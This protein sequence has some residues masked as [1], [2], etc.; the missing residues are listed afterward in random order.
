MQMIHAE[1]A[2]FL[3][4]LDQ[5]R[6]NLRIIVDIDSSLTVEACDMLCYS[7]SNVPQVFSGTGNDSEN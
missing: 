5:R 1:A 2:A 3:A 4:D 6:I 7:I